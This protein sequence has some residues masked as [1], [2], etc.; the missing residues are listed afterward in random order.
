M[1]L[2]IGLRN[3]RVVEGK[4]VCAVCKGAVCMDAYCGMWMNVCMWMSVPLRTSCVS[5]LMM[6]KASGDAA[7]INSKTRAN[8]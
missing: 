5:T 2:G 6:F 3:G 7:S 1:G 4:Y 8:V